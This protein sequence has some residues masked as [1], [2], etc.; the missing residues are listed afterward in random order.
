MLKYFNSEYLSRYLVLFLFP[1][2]CWLTSYFIPTEII[3]GRQPLYQLY[4]WISSDYFYLQNS[5]ALAVTILTALMVNN[6]IKSFGFSGKITTLGMFIALILACAL[7]DQIRM[8]PYLWINLIFIFL[9]GYLYVMPSK[10][11]NIPTAYN[12]GLLLGKISSAGY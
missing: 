5:I 4:L 3:T 9:F 1:A 2:V 10:S 6:L 7:S 8:S 11:N 12:A